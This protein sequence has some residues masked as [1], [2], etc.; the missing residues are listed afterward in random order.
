[1]ENPNAGVGPVPTPDPVAP[2][3]PV[4]PAAEPVAEPAPTAEPTPVVE[5]APATEP[6]AEP[7]APNAEP[8]PAT[9][10]T[11]APAA[12]AEP[13]A[14]K[15]TP[16]G[17]IIGLVA[18]GIVFLAA[19][20]LIPIIVIVMSNSI[21]GTY[22]L[23]GMERYGQTMSAEEIAEKDY[24]ATLELKGGGDCSLDI[25]TSGRTQSFGACY[26][27]DNKIYNSKEKKGTSIDMEVDGKR[28]TINY[29]GV[30][31]IFEK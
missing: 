11:P 5:A 28:I 23:V 24:A 31:M 12:T 9:P 13:A 14:K 17:L 21:A 25:T 27:E 29:M 7:V 18:G 8:T 20:I 2:A 15:K 3:E 4:A 10:A 6:V 22:K 30:K 1:M 26:Y 16:V 19:A